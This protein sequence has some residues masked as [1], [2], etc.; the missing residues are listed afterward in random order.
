MTLAALLIYSR[1]YFYIMPE[2]TQSTTLNI[3][4][5]ENGYKECMIE[6]GENIILEESKYIIN[7]FIVVPE[8]F[9]HSNITEINVDLRDDNKIIG[10]GYKNLKK[11]EGIAGNVKKGIEA[12]G[13]ISG[14]SDDVQILQVTINAY[15]DIS[16]KFL[17]LTIYPTQI[18]IQKIYAKFEAKLTGIRY[19]LHE[20]FFISCFFGV[21]WIIII[22]VIIGHFAQETIKKRFR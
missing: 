4:L 1:L 15:I 19:V 22:E 3:Y 10:K 9:H 18:Q 12:L 16:T 6:I 2:L 14:I 8:I 5:N 11:Y 21:F 20:Y 13:V 17:Y 7:I